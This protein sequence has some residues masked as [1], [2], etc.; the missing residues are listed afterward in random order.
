VKQHGP[1]PALLNK[2]TAAK[3]YFHPA[4]SAGPSQ[5]PSGEFQIQYQAGKDQGDINENNLNE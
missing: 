2:G 3:A 4:A 1:T 5:A